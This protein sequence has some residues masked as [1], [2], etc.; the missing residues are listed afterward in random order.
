MNYLFCLTHDNTKAY[1]IQLPPWDALFL[2]RWLSDTSSACGGVVHESG[3]DNMKQE[4]ESN[5]KQIKSDI[6]NIVESEM[7]RIK[8][9]PD[10]QHLV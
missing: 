1:I 8:N 2:V 4:I 9:D 7:E 5:Y 10:L 3:A 6:V